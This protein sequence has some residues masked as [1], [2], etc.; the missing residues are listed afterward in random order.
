[1]LLQGRSVGRADAYPLTNWIFNG[2]FHMV[3]VKRFY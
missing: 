2:D 3:L 1:V